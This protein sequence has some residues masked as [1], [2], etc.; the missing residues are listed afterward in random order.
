[1]IPVRNAQHP[2]RSTTPPA[3]GAALALLG[4]AAVTA[5]DCQSTNATSLSPGLMANPRAL[6]FSACPTRDE[7]HRLVE[8]VAPDRQIFRVQ[9]IGKASAMLSYELRGSGAPRFA[10]APETR[11]E[12]L[13]SGASAEIAVVFTPLQRG[14]VTAELV[15]DDGSDA[16]E[17]LVIPLAGTG[18]ALPAQP[19]LELRY[20]DRD[21]GAFT[22]CMPSIS[23]TID[24]CLVEWPPAFYDESRTLTLKVRNLGCG[25]MNVTELRLEPYAGGQ[26]QYFLDAPRILPSAV[27]PVTLT[28][29]AEMDV[30]IRF[31][32]AADPSALSESRYAVLT[33]GTNADNSPVSSVLLHGEAVAPACYVTP[34]HCDFTSPADTC[35]GTK[36]PAGGN[37]TVASFRITNGGNTP[38]DIPSITFR[39]PNNGRFAPGLRNPVGETIAPSDSKVLDIEYTDEPL[40]VTEALDIECRAGATTAGKPSITV[41]GGVLPCLYT[42]PDLQL[43]FTGSAN[44]VSTRAVDVCNGS[45]CGVL[46][47]RRLE[48]VQNL[49]GNFF[50]VV[51]GTSPA[52]QNVQPGACAPVQI[53]L[54][55]PVTGGLQT[56]T[57]EIESN[58]P[59]FAAPSYKRINLLSTAP[60]DQVP[61]AVLKGPAGE[62][63]AF[64]VSLAALQTKR[65]PLRGGES[66]DP[67]NNTPATKFRWFIAKKPLNATAS[68]TETSTAGAE[69]NVH[70]SIL[71]RSA[72]GDTIDLHVDPALPGEYRV[73]LR[74][75]DSADQASGNVAELRVLVDP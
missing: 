8:G 41:S 2:S 69:P 72:G 66:Y 54:T 44:P 53:Q 52:G 13:P 67:P 58:D 18:S 47:I 37:H 46:E 17:P 31:A 22:A 9:N 74:V 70:G 32:P 36:T 25:P 59:N 65:I 10:I 50:T 45:G 75:Y 3:W 38:V 56:A 26:L 5:C 43:D 63:Y 1:V 61:V 40:Y 30:S 28:N 27:S 21:T 48:V 7:N 24:N 49:G 11:V 42:N 60:L 35:H 71:A 51:P 64:R 57:L 33:V 29:A 73:A 20:A 15:I 39:N 62:T 23:G 55:R 34:S 4:L 19:T 12:S 68:L 14:D 16:T 6:S